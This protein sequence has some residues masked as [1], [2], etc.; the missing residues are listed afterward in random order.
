MTD[1]SAFERALPQRPLLRGMFHLPAAVAAIAGTVLLLLLAD[2]ARAYAGA[3][4]FG[5]S[6]ILL[7]TTSAAYHRI[8]GRRGCGA[9]PGGWT[10]R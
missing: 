10:T 9:S 2:S 3:A 4:I 1:S 6:L 5:A 7:Y 8:P